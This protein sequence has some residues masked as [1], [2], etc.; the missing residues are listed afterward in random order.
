MAQHNSLGRWGE[1]VAAEYLTVRGYAIVRRN[2]RMGHLEI[3]II[4]TRGARIIFVE[5]KT[6]STGDYDP[7]EAVDMR[8]RN[9]MIASADAYI[10]MYDIPYEVQYDIVTVIGDPG[11]HTVEHIPDA[12]L[13]GVRARR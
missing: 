11:N 4:A 1:N 13:P 10:R 6:R 5:V 3:D 8:K 9:R 7:V 12:F 2:W